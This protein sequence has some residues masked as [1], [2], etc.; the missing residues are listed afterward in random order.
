MITY[1]DEWEGYLRQ[2]VGKNGKPF[3]TFEKSHIVRS[4]INITPAQA[5]ILN[6][7]FEGGGLNCLVTQYLPVETD[8]K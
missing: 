6:R 7:G 3:R 1:Y 4:S 5:E 8:S 2:H